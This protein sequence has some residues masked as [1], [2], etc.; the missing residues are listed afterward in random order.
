MQASWVSLGLITLSRV[1]AYWCFEPGRKF[2]HL[3]LHPTSLLWPLIS[4]RLFTLFCN[5]API[6]IPT[7]TYELTKSVH[8]T[9]P[10]PSF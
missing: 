2:T 7:L 1:S 6:Q 10:L 4:L 9:H 3:V 8:L 5:A